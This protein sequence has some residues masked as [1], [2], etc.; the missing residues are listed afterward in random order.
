MMSNR[1]LISSY[2]HQ[3]PSTGEMGWMVVSTFEVDGQTKRIPHWIPDTAFVARP[4]EYGFD[5]DD[6]D[7]LLDVILNEPFTVVPRE[8]EHLT[9]Y[10]SADEEPTRKA[11]VRRC[12]QVKLA[13]R[14][15]TRSNKSTLRAKAADP[16]DPTTAEDVEAAHPLDAI[17]E[18]LRANPFPPEQRAYCKFLIDNARGNPAGYLP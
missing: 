1:K 17:R 16:G 2:R 4:L 11:H 6:Y 8:E 15:S 14:L 12:A 18:H 5:P 3:H 7:T 10:G 13:H 9:I